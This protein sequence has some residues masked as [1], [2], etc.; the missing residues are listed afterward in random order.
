MGIEED[1]K[2]GQNSK[3]S[4]PDSVERASIDFFCGAI[5]PILYPCTVAIGC[6]ALLCGDGVVSRELLTS[7][8]NAIKR[9][10]KGKNINYFVGLA[11]SLYGIGYGFSSLIQ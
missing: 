2:N 4:K 10:I 11:S 3:S 7:T 1:T 8:P 6:G 5:T 9:S